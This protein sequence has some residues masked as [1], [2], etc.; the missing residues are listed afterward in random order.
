[1]LLSSCVLG[2]VIASWAGA[3]WITVPIVVSAVNIAPV[4][5]RCVICGAGPVGLASALTLAKSKKAG[6]DEITVVERREE[7]AFE[8]EKAYLYL[9]DGRGQKLTDSL[10]GLTK[11]FAELSVSSKQFTELT[12]VLTDGTTNVKKLPVLMGSGVE[13][14]WMP[15]KVMI[16]GFLQEIEVHNRDSG[17]KA[18]KIEVIFN[19]QVTGLSYVGGGSGI[20]VDLQQENG[21][22]KA[23]PGA[24]LVVGADG[25][26]SFVRKS[27]AENSA[28]GCDESYIPIQKE[29]DSAGLEFKILTPN[30]RFSLP[31]PEGVSRA[32]LIGE[33]EV[34]HG[35]PTGTME[36]DPRFAAL[37]G[38]K[39]H[40]EAG[41]ETEAQVKEELAARKV[42]EKEDQASVPERAYAIRG[43]GATG[44]T[45]LS[46]GLLPVKGDAP[47]TCNFVA[48]PGHELWGI[49]TT[50]EMRSYMEKQFPQ[51]SR[52]LADF[53]SDK[54]LDR[55]VQARP[56]HFP[57]PQ[58]C[59]SPCG[60]VVPTAPGSEVCKISPRVDVDENEEGQGQGVRSQ[61]ALVLL[62]DS[63][64]AF[65]PDLGQGVNSGLEDVHE[66]GRAIDSTDG[67]LKRALPLFESRRMPE[68]RALIDLM[69]FG[70][71]YQY[72][73]GPWWK[74]SATTANFAL[75]LL[76]S[77]ALPFLFAPPA[78]FMI[79]DPSLSYTTILNRAHRTTAAFILI[80]V[81]AVTFTAFKA[82]A[83]SLLAKVTGA[84]STITGTSAAGF[85]A[86]L[87]VR[88]FRVD[89]ESALAL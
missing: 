41:V 62:G 9:L 72:N 59:P 75:R 76:A 55:F 4:K 61:A 57:K 29:S 64:H 22:K 67:D 39:Q 2:V 30:H 52:P 40:Q 21:Q 65:P 7:R 19:T 88:V 33:E 74:K 46:M 23:L 80:S 49:D 25:M 50:D 38:L 35:S 18:P 15:R 86:W 48:K 69:V 36:V 73:Q 89:G 68:V 43:V 28:D 78:F 58:Y 32:D 20:E 85:L 87:A 63:L 26:N 34:Q 3:L 1:M 42:R 16:D 10:D 44:T 31:L 17:P 79:Q 11:K 84:A 24:A 47:R 83:L 8:A 6:F 66:L 60:F 54:E 12:E 13:K 56:G 27:M 71:P 77:K 82:A 5:R 37:T 81:L 51:M 45:R 53:V 14:Y 70:Y